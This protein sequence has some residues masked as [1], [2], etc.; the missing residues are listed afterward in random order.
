VSYIQSA[1]CQLIIIQ[2]VILNIVSDYVIFFLVIFTELVMQ[3][4]TMQGDCICLSTNR[5][6]KFVSSHHTLLQLNIALR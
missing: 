2:S 6:F 4:K 3:L 1:I 5:I